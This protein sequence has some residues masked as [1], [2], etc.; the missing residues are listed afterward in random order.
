MNM[1]NLIKNQCYYEQCYYEKFHVALCPGMASQPQ[2]DHLF[3]CGHVVNVQ[4]Q[5]EFKI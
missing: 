4:M 1:C 3:S 5:S 2:Q